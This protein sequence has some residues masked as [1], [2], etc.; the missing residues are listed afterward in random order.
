M[1]KLL[2]IEEL[3]LFAACLYFYPCLGLSWWW[4]VAFIL[5]P[6]VGML[7]YLANAKT[8]AVVYNLFHHRG[9][10]LIVFFGGLLTSS[11]WTEFAGLILFAH[12]SMDRML[13]YGLKY[14]KGFRYTHLGIVGHDNPK[15]VTLR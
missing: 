2:Q 3:F 8:G 1:K 10:A 9:I 5:L 11:V 7:G 4:F 15:E 12:A 6:D 14:A 13:G